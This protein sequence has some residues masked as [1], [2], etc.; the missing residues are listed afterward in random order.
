V[1]IVKVNVF[2]VTALVLS[3]DLNDAP[4]FVIRLYSVPSQMS[5]NSVISSF[6]SFSSTN[7][8]NFSSGKKERFI[9]NNVKMIESSN[10]K[11]S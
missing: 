8:Q 7:E 4:A 3:F 1:F 9:N 11:F 2:S 6:G 5:V 10:D